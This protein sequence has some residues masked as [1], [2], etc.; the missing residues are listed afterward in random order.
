VQ[1]AE[2]CGGRFAGQALGRAF[3]VAAQNLHAFR[4]RVR[5][6][7]AAHAGPPED[8]RRSAP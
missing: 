4:A 1:I 7:D 6:I 8:L 3:V 5:R 2:S